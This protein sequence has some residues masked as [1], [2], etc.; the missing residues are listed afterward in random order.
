ME[1]FV[2]GHVGKI[3][4]DDPTDAS[5]TDGQHIF[6][7]IFFFTSSNTRSRVK[8]ALVGEKALILAVFSLE[9]CRSFVR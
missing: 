9:E 4:A 8:L 6:I 5:V 2:V 1:K 3:A 7:R